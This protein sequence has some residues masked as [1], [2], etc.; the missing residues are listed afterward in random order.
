VVISVVD[1]AV[2]WASAAALAPAKT[3]T[4]MVKEE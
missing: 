2:A 1:S 3:V 4:K